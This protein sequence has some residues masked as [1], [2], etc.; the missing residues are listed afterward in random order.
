MFSQ[1]KVDF[2]QDLLWKNI[3]ELPYFR[4]FLRAIEGRFYQDVYLEEPILDI[5]CGDGHFSARTFKDLPIIG[6]DP[7]L[8][9]LKE[10]KNFNF[11]PGLICSDGERLPFHKESFN[12]IICNSV[13]EHIKDV[14]SVICEIYRILKVKGSFIFSVP[15]SN[16]TKNLSLAI[17][18]EKKELSFIS[19]NYR[20][21]FNK[22][23]RH[24]HVDATEKW[25]Q[26]VEKVGFQICKSFE[27]FPPD[28]LKILEWGH[29]FGLPSLI[30]KKLLG[31]WVLW[32]SMKNPYLKMID[33]YL[34]KYFNRDPISTRGAYSFI[35]AQK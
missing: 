8:K 28:Y 14:D 7:N 15:N 2:E 21:W 4:G 34:F 33:S 1:R 26:R 5:G 29:Y 22:I 25:K 13:L 30:N 9:M 24:Y 16:F 35:V 32:D 31:K 11:F 18:F 17:F 6:I 19:K 20:R 10:A 12:T 3:S 27:Y 23:S